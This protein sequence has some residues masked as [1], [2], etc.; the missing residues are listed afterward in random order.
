MFTGI[1]SGQGRIVSRLRRGPEAEL[2]V[3][4]LSPWDPPLSVGESIAVSGVCLTVS[5]I[6]GGRAFKA[7]ASG[8]TLSLSTLGQ[9]DRVNLERALRL[10]D[11]L[12]GH[13]VTGHVD[14]LTTLRERARVG[15]SLRCVFSLPADLE[16]LVAPKGSVAIDGVSLTVNAAVPGSGTFS[17]NLI[18]QTSL[19][20]TISSKMPGE[21][22]NLEVDILARY[23]GRLLGTSPPRPGLSIS[24][25]IAQGF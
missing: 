1:V 17:V 11:R 22:L 13:L 20:T 5:D 10:S 25:L 14:A 6:Q 3:E 7:H 21:R 16:P 24:E 8:E 12:G 19:V 2:T 9:D 18:P 15:Q 4:S 23:V